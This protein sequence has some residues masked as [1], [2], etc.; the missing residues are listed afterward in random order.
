[1]NVREIDETAMLRERVSGL[2]VELGEAK[3]VSETNLAGLGVADR[4][5]KVTGRSSLDNAIATTKRLAATL[6]RALDESVAPCV[7]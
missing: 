3:A 7:R 2:L 4:F 1:M 6:D 5:K